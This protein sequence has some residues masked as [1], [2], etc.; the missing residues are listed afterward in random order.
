MRIYVRRRE[1]IT[2]LGGAAAWPLTA[3]AQQQPAVPVI[4]YLS[5]ISPIGIG[6][7][8]L[9]GVRQGLRD[10]GF[11]EGQNLIVEYRWAEGQLDRLPALA[12]DLVRRQVS[13]IATT[14]GLAPAQ[15]AIAAT[16]TIPIVFQT[17]S[18]PV[19]LGV[20]A[21]LNRPGGN[22]TGVTSM[23]YEIL[24]KRLAVLLELAP[25]V[26]TV[27]QIINPALSDTNVS[28]R[29]R[30]PQRRVRSGGSILWSAFAMPST[31]KRHSRRSPSARPMHS[32]SPPTRY[33]AAIAA[34]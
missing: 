34:G 10:T 27:A 20:V 3:R 11:V 13:V 25:Q 17:A 22:V 21:S 29:T 14:N 4:G 32:L 1:F 19:Q 18:D 9:T 15:A 7:T 24:G 5:P 30:W 12:A 33:S 16:S 8:A 28:A 31:L 2:T 26:K 23:S 6:Q